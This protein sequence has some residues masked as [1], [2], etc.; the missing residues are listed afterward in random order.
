[1][2]SFLKWTNSGSNGGSPRTIFQSWLKLSPESKFSMTINLCNILCSRVDENTDEHCLFYFRHKARRLLKIDRI[3]MVDLSLNNVCVDNDPTL[4]ER[5]LR[6][7]RI[8]GRS[9]I[10]KSDSVKSVKVKSDRCKSDRHKSRKSKGSS[11]KSGSE[12]CDRK[13]K[14]SQHKSLSS[15]VRSTKVDLT[16]LTTDFASQQGQMSPTT[17]DSM[18]Q[19]GSGNANS[20]TNAS[21]MCLTP[22]IHDGD[23]SILSWGSRIESHA[24]VNITYSP[25]YY[26]C[27]FNLPQREHNN[28]QFYQDC[29]YAN[30]RNSFVGGNMSVERFRNG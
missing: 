5:K 3:M 29:S 30:D 1:M 10:V 11:S 28:L 24:N 2:E 13:R 4:L 18:E 22:Y 15:K 8:C 16:P 6:S 23:Q 9:S 12:K 26:T 27:N 7:K 19:R 17:E 20:H 21:N 14:K 25:T